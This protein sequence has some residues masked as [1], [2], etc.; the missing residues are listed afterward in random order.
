MS[1]HGSVSP[2]ERLVAPNPFLHSFLVSFLVGC[3]A[4]PAKDST[5]QLCCCYET[6]FWLKSVDAVDVTTGYCLT[7]RNAL[8]MYFPFSSNE[9]GQ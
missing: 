1:L 2:A 3:M 7:K 6:M 5:S 4:I 9:M 8:H